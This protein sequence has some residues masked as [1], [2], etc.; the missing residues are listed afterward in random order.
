MNFEE[1]NDRFLLLRGIFK[2]YIKQNIVKNAYSVVICRLI[3]KFNN[4]KK[5]PKERSAK[6][7][8]KFNP[9]FFG[10]SFQTIYQNPRLVS[11]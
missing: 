11:T 8:F 6:V 7:F 5:D 1:K 10:V 4:V 3:K 9:L 2:E